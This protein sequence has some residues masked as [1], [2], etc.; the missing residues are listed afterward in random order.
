VS[1][2]Q[3][4]WRNIWRNRRRTVVTIAAMTIAMIATI[5]YS[6]LMNGYVHGMERNILDF[7]FG[8]IQIH[9]PG[10]RD[11]PSLYK[12]I[13]NPA[14]LLEKL[15]TAKLPGSARLLAAGL[16]AL[17]DTSSGV[18]LIG[19]DVGRDAKV[20][21]IPSQVDR[22][23]WLS[24]ADSHGVVLGRR[25]ARTLDAEPGD[26]LVILG[27]ATDGSLANDL[28]KVRGVLRGVTDMTDRIGVFMLEKTFRELMVM[29]SGAHQ[30]VVRKPTQIELAAA[31][32]TVSRLAPGQDVQTWRQLSP[33]LASMVDNVQSVVM[34]FV[35]IVYIA[36][37][38][39]ILN[40]MLMAVFERVREFG[41][42]K[43][44]GAGPGRVLKMIYT[45][46]A[47]QTGIAIAGGMLL[48]IPLMYYLT[49]T[50]IFLGS[51]EGL[52]VMGLAWDPNL[53]ALF[54]VQSFTRPVV[55]FTIIVALAVLYPALK[56]A[57]IRPV[58]A[59][60]HR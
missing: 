9:A 38:L 6:G 22:G 7:A 54:D 25:L 13:G 46:S 35:F 32:E 55:M 17:K 50:G 47:I 29:P 30:I 51:E 19:L 21:K 18:M 60:H 45:E 31:Q 5:N 37:A 56:A 16:G 44:L 26:E 52:A 59:M 10:Y 33:T 8:D 58:R 53:R 41:V 43:A 40:A 11:K 48:S 4:A 36:I 1:V 23:E 57:M 24:D 28:F 42:L 27:Q 2:A 34:V 39:V 15:D 12:R 20:S 14:E 49:N 3:L